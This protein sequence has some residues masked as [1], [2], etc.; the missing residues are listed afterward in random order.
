MGPLSR[1]EHYKLFSTTEEEVGYQTLSI[2]R[3]MY[4]QGFEWFD[5]VFRNEPEIEKN[6]FRL[7]ATLF[8]CDIFAI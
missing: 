2:D 5:F 7:R 6:R 8:E 1:E 4:S 3:V